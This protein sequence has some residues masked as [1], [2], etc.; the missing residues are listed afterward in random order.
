MKLI[1]RN[2]SLKFETVKELEPFGGS[3]NT[4]AN[5]NFTLVKLEFE[6]PFAFTGRICLASYVSNGVFQNWQLYQTNGKNTNDR[7]GQVAIVTQF[8]PKSVGDSQGYESDYTT[9]N[10]DGAASGNRCKITIVG[11][12][13]QFV[14]DELESRGSQTFTGTC[15]IYDE[16]DKINVL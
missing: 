8:S 15:F 14:Q 5:N 9:C 10:A 16:S 6:Q 12:I 7:T 1:L 3:S 2:T 4:A 13:T 11:D